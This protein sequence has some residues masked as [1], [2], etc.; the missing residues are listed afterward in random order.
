M[1]TSR[2]SSTKTRIETFWGIWMTNSPIDIKSKFHE[3]KDWNLVTFLPMP[4]SLIIK[5]KFHENKDWN[6]GWWAKEGRHK[7]HQEQVP[8][9]QGLKRQMQF[10]ILDSKTH[11]EQVPRKQGLKLFSSNAILVSSGTSRAS[12]TKTR[13]ETIY[14]NNRTFFI[15]IHQ[16]QVPRKQGLKLN[17]TKRWSLVKF[18]HQEQVPR[19]Q[20][21]KLWFV[22]PYLDSGVHIKSKFHENKDWN[23]SAPGW[24]NKSCKHQE[25]VPRKQGLKLQIFFFPEITSYHQEQVPRKQGLKHI[26][27]KSYRYRIYPSRASSTKTRIETR[28]SYAMKFLWQRIKSKFHENKDW[29]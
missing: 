11:Q 4:I 23:S 8:R 3:N 15:I 12:S 17:F 18:I 6:S 28:Q 10:T 13:I 2:A 9:K 14:S 19:K 5:S 1:R 24:L 16:E 26:M 22:L 29:N 20:G 7:K 25:Q 21:L 27:R